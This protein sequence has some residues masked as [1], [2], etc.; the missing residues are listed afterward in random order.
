MINHGLIYGLL[1]TTNLMVVR[2]TILRPLKMDSP[3]HVY[4]MSL[5]NEFDYVLKRSGSQNVEE[6]PDSKERRSQ[7]GSSFIRFGRSHQANLESPDN[8]G[9][10]MNSDDSGSS[11]IPRGRSDVII[12][13]GRS[14]VQSFNFPRVSS[15]SRSSMI[16]L[17]LTKLAAIC[18]SILT[19]PESALHND[20]LLRICTSLTL[21]SSDFDV[22]QWNN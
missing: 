6:S 3:S 22:N 9:N 12:R 21:Q 13:F 16:P 18:P 20:L 7:M 5:D 15:A 2:G 19:N 1:I 8:S 4:K 17:N 11:R 14:G 10:N